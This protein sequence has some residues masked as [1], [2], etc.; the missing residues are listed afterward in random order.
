MSWN[1][2]GRL[3]RVTTFGESHGRS[4][5][6]VVDG[7]P[8]GMELSTDDVQLELNLR[9]PGTSA[10]VSPRREPDRVEVISGLFE[11]R[12]TGAPVCM[13]VFNEEARPE[14]YD[15]LKDLYRPGHADITYQAKYGLR[16]HRGGGRASGR[17]TVGRVAAGAIARRLLLA[18][19]VLV[20]GHVVQIGSVK[21][22]SGS[23]EESRRNSVRCRDSQAASRMSGEIER[24]R[25]ENDSLGG[26]VEVVASNVPAGWGDPVF[27]K[28]DALLAYGLM[29]IGAV[30]GV[31]VGAGFR[32]VELRGS[33]ANDE[34]LPGSRFASNNHGGVLGGISS[35]ADV[36]VRVA[37][38]PTSS[39]GA[40]QRTIQQDGRPA[41]VSVKGRHDPCICPRLVPVAEAMVCLVLAD[42]MLAQ[43]VFG[44]P[45]LIGV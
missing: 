27:G 29:S 12:T 37:V 34:I 39:I 43:Q 9:R 21:A 14:D 24:A 38:K 15:H 33:E 44:A 30:K 8:P 28:L 23:W 7:V 25:G 19:D 41:V 13:V 35:G 16:D 42:A 18:R 11:G 26:V 3:L 32:V 45:R 22:S 10:D 2:F 4:I 40:P 36:I 31:E 6:V 17:E 20:S 1:T 5:G